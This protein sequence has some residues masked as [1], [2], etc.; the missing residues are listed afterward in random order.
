MLNAT[1]IQANRGKNVVLSAMAGWH[2]PMLSFGGF[3]ALPLC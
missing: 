1:K 2:E 3:N